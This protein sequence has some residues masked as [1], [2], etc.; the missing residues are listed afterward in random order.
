[1][2]KT[3]FLTDY[4]GQKERLR[5]KAF[6]K[7]QASLLTEYAFFIKLEKFLPRLDGELTEQPMAGSFPTR[8]WWKPNTES[9]SW[10]FGVVYLS[11]PP[12]RLGLTQG[13]WPESRLQCEFRGG[14]GSARVDVRDLLVSA[15]HRPT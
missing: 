5:C 13:Q 8:W 2:R 3:I 9:T 7:T 15:S 4:E 10:C 12:T 1:M 14:E 11:L 6:P